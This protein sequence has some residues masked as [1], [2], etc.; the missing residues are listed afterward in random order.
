MEVIRRGLR[1]WDAHD[2]AP[3]PDDVFQERLYC[4]RW[5]ETYEDEKGRIRTRRHFRAPTQADIAREARVCE[6][7]AE[8]FYEWQDKGYLPRR[9]I[10]PGDETAR[11]QRERGWTYW[12]HLFTP[13]QLLLL[14]LLNE[15]ID[16]EPLSL[17]Q[18]VG[19]VLSLGRCADWNSRL[20]RWNSDGANEKTEQTFS[21]QALNTL[22]N[23]GSR[24]VVSLDT[25]WFAR[26]A[27]EPIHGT[28]TVQA[29]D[30]RAVAEASDI[31]ITDPPYAD[32]VNYHELSEYFLG[33]YESSLTRLFPSW[34]TRLEARTRCSRGKR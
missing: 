18:R 5:V 19:C 4:I 2:V 1:M 12:H 11:L 24:T 15:T 20:C 9:R 8:R 14:G 10:E 7:L 28:A 31:W 21:N 3:Q 16:R 17:V 23:Y 32:A 34:Y 30:C 27:V 22:V 6:L 26:V 29:A 25:T 13:R 33:W